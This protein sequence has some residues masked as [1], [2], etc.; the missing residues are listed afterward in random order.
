M[1]IC[2]ICEQEFLKFGNFGNLRRHWKISRLHTCT[3]CD[4]EFA[5][6]ASL[7]RHKKIVHSFPN[8]L[9]RAR[10]P[11]QPIRRNS[12]VGLDESTVMEPWNLTPP[13]VKKTANPTTVMR[14][15]DVPVVKKPKITRH[16]AI[17]RRKRCGIADIFSSDGE[18]VKRKQKRRA[19]MKSKHGYSVKDIQTWLKKSPLC[20]VSADQSSPTCADNSVV[21]CQSPTPVCTVTSD[22]LGD[23]ATQ[24]KPSS[25]VTL[26]DEQSKLIIDI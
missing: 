24:Y 7:L 4:R 10:K 15:S 22:A 11:R 6:V 8:P 13:L 5:G 1:D 14:N 16:G 9:T 21:D 3:T 17:P 12:S 18:P 25:D 23:P 26:S 2:R 20:A 19:P